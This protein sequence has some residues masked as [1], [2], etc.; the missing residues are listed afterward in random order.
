MGRMRMQSIYPHG[1]RGAFYHSGV[2]AVICMHWDYGGL[3]APLRY[4]CLAL[5]QGWPLTA[6]L[7]AVYKRT[8]GPFTRGRFFCGESGSVRLAT[9]DESEWR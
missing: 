8:R 7:Q 9:S 5:Y 6:V 3:H 4:P 2:K 1:I